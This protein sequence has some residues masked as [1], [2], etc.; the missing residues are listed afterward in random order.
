MEGQCT[1][2]ARGTQGA[3]ANAIALPPPKAV[4]D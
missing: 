3:L 1:K 2:D 4:Y